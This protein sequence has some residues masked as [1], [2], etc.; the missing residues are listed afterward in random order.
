MLPLSSKQSSDISFPSRRQIILLGGLVLVLVLLA[1][2]PSLFG[3]F[4]S[5]DDDLLVFEN[6]VVQAMTP[7]TLWKI[8]TMYD[9]ELYIPLTFF[10]YQINYLIG[11]MSPFVYH[12]TNILLHAGNA[13]LVTGIAYLLLRG[14]RI[15]ALLTGLLFAVHPLHTEAVAWIS[16]RKDILSAFFFLLA[17]F[18]FLLHEERPSQKKYAGIFIAFLCALLSKVSAVTF[19]VMMFLIVCYRSGKISRQ[20]V[21][22]MIPFFALSIIFGVI[23]LYGKSGQMGAVHPLE[24]FF[25]AARSIVFYLQKIVAPVSLSIFYPFDAPIAFTTPAIF[26]SCLILGALIVAS[27]LLYR[28]VRWPFLSLLAFGILLAPTFINYRRG[29]AAQDV[30]FAS[31]RYAYLASIIALLMIAALL[32]R[33]MR[34]SRGPVLLATS[35]IV[36][37]FITLSFSQSRLWQGSIPL[38]THALSLYP[39]AQTAHNN[40][41]TVYY[42][43]GDL[44]NAEEHYKQAIALRPLASTWSNLGT[45]Y[46]KQGKLQESLISFREAIRTNPGEYDAYFGL[47][48]LL[49][50][51][52]KFPEAEEA[53]RRARILDPHD[54]GAPLN[55]GALYVQQGRYAEAVEQYLRALQIHPHYPNA[56]YN[57][58][59]V[60]RRMGKMEEARQA[61]EHALK[62]RPDMGQAEVQLQEMRIE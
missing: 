55:L 49:S 14:N 58:G 52:G 48:I 34:R 28:R 32:E 10:S 44:E 13:L 4:I 53:Y 31:D 26:V 40:L 1:F 38:F 23:A 60:Y 6:P 22:R 5:W 24:I 18:L 11:G 35:A 15:A 54:P 8:F 29:F 50:Q 36:I 61:F 59:V 45:L 42:Q 20:D 21:K 9:P 37:V 19:P 47:G 51:A 43:K 3:E 57:L 30:Y 56:Y 25:M 41:G 33:G 12:L 17:T 27:I 62:Y 7:W 46:R 39:T 2:G 16:A